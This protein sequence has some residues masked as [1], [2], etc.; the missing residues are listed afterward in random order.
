MRTSGSHSLLWCWRRLR[1]TRRTEESEE[2]Q[3]NRPGENGGLGP[4]RFP[5]NRLELLFAE[6]IFFRLELCNFVCQRRPLGTGCCGDFL[7]EFIYLAALRGDLSSQFFRCGRRVV[8][9]D[10]AG[11]LRPDEHAKTE[12]KQDQQ[13]LSLRANL[14]R[15]GLVCVDLARNEKEIVT[16]AVQ[17]DT[18]D[19]H[20]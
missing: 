19:D 18:A 9:F 1:F 5:F 10:F 3:E 12:R 11:Y 7:A 4:K 16:N 17:N 14:F 15:R 13:T 20:P 6:C 2:D 8:S